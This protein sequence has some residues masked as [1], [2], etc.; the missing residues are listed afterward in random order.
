MADV[1][2]THLPTEPLSGI[3]ATPT[4]QTSPKAS[5]PGLTPPFV[6][7]DPFP[8]HT[9]QTTH[10]LVRGWSPRTSVVTLF[11]GPCMAVVS[12]EALS[13]GYF[14]TLRLLPSGSDSSL[15]STPTSQPS[16]CLA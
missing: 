7:L 16:I 15:P 9:Q 12:L 13:A 1:P 14:L 10:A 2:P 8:S 4:D 6:S 3:S 11:C 5:P